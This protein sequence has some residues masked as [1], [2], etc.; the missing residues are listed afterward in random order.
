VKRFTRAEGS[1]G[2]SGI[3]RLVWKWS[4]KREG[5]ARPL[6]LEPESASLNQPAGMVPSREG[7]FPQFLGP[8]RSGVLTGIPLRRGNLDSDFGDNLSKRCATGIGVLHAS[9]PQEAS[10][11]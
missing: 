3:P 9:N 10:P 5:S 1:I 4:P 8:D 7:A 6:L 11:N 2:G